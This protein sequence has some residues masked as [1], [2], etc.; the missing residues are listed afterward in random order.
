MTLIQKIQGPFN[1]RRVQ[2]CIF[3]GEKAL[4]RGMPG[5]AAFFFRKA[6]KRGNNAQARILY[7]IAYYKLEFYKRAEAQFTKAIELEP[8]NRSA[9]LWRA[10]AKSALWDLNGAIE[11]LHKALELA[12]GKNGTAYEIYCELGKAFYSL[13]MYRQAKEYFTSAIQMNPGRATA[14]GG[15]MRACIMLG[16]FQAAIND[17]MQIRRILAEHQKS[18]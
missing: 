5:K 3:K 16:E 13:Q 10:K 2:R 4:S 9:H 7:G 14:Y 1:K 18:R 6:L 15:R 11:D 12:L 17:R 8:T